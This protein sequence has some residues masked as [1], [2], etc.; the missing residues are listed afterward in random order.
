MCSCQIAV[1]HTHTSPNS[2][3]TRCGANDTMIFIVTFP[4]TWSFLCSLRKGVTVPSSVFRK[5]RFSKPK[6]FLV[7]ALERNEKKVSRKT[8]KLS[9]PFTKRGVQQFL[10]IWGHEAWCQVVSPHRLVAPS[11]VA[12]TSELCSP[13]IE[14]VSINSNDYTLYNH[15][16]D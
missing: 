10:D 12:P 9:S 15:N 11:Y 4:F 8:T 5:H 7:K 6:C 13:N 14:V 16:C 2:V 1:K 3:C